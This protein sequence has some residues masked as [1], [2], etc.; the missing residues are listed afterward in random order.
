MESK[1]MIRPDP[2]KLKQGFSLFPSGVVIVTTRDAD[3]NDHGFT[4][5]TFVPLSVEPPMVLV[6]LNRTAQ[7][8]D[9]FIEAES[10]AVSVLRPAHEAVA[11]RFATRGA[12]KF[13]DLTLA[14]T[15]DGLPILA[16]ALVAFAC[17]TAGHHAGGDHTILTGRVEG[18]HQTGDREAMVHFA[19]AF[20]MVQG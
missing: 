17:G 16:D 8:H 13:S 6:C 3:G 2:A 18:L 20:H 7:C 10:F 9:V 14:R 19:R 11:L 4:A 15:A 1:D 5:S 12:D